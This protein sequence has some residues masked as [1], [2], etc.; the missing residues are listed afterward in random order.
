M[1]LYWSIKFFSPVQIS[2][3]SYKK[4]KFNLK[5]KYFGYYVLF[6]EK[7]IKIKWVYA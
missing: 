3:H 7:I 5:Q 2:K 1:I 6:S 4:I